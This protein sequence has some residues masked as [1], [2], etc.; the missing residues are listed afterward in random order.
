MFVF[1]TDKEQKNEKGPRQ[2]RS[3]QRGLINERGRTPAEK[4]IEEKM[5]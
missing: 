1:T 4:K 3:R 2:K 5:N